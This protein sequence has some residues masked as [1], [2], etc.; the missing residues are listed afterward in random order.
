MLSIKWKVHVPCP[1]VSVSGCP[2]EALDKSTCYLVIWLS[3]FDVRERAMD[4]RH[5][6]CVYNSPRY[7][8]G[9]GYYAFPAV[10]AVMLFFL[11]K[12]IIKSS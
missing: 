12:F 4:I 3:I 10:L 2:Q 8:A 7:R 9:A 11:P 6:S 5:R 1:T